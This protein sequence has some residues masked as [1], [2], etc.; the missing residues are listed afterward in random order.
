MEGKGKTICGNSSCEKNQELTAYE[1]NMNY[2][3]KDEQKNALVKVYLCRRCGKRLR[4][5]NKIRR[6]KEKKKI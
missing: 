3:E 2:V 4:K 6:K 1:V 5:I